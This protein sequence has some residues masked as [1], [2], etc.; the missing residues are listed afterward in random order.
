M[1]ELR[2]N[3][4]KIL[5]AKTALDGHWRGP[6]VVTEALSEAGFEVTFMGMATPEE[7][8][9][10]AQAEEPD[11]IGL[12]VGGRIEVVKRIVALIRQ[13]LPDTPIFVGGTVP[14][15]AKKDLEE[16]GIE[17]YPPGSKLKDIVEAAYR[18]T[19]KFERE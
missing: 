7:I 12:N 1:N 10:S 6:I 11:L 5:F 16:I 3:S 19:E 8:A 4:R 9:G 18:L 15:W 13:H 14:P 2:R 17:V